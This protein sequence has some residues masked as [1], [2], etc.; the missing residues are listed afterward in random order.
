MNSYSM[1]KLFLKILQYSQKNTCVR[2][3]FNENPGLQSCNFIK[4]RLQ[5]R[6]FSVNIAKFLRIPI[7]KEIYERLFERFPT[8]TN[9]IKSNI[10][11]GED[12]FSK[13]KQTKPF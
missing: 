8:W 4:E 3:F 11:S 13:T 9:N 5:H 1:K 2:V 6:C 12:T 10:G 7:L